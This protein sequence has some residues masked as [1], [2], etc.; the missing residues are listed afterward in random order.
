M[1][2]AVYH[3]YGA[4]DVLHLEDVPA[5]TPKADEVLIEIHATTVTAGDWRARSL[6]LPAGFG[7]LGR[8]V[9]GISKPRQPVLG[10]ELAGRVVAIGERVTDFAVGD[11]VF[12][13][14]GA[15]MGCHAEYRCISQ[16]G[17]IARIPD[18]LTYEQATALSFGGTTALEFLRKAKL[19]P[20]ERVLVVGASGGV[21]TA[22]LQLAK[23]FGAEV[24]GVCSTANLELVRSLGADHV[25]DYTKE[26]F[27]KSGQ[28]YDVIVDTAGTAPFSRSKHALRDGGRLL[29]VLGGLGDLFL[30]LWVSL[31]SRKKLIA[32]P[33][34]GTAEDLRLLARLA[35]A[36][37]VRP[38][39]DRRYP[40]AQIVEAHRYV[41]TGRKRGSVVM[42][43]LPE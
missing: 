18:A 2:A 30:A 13:F 8:L 25:I 9:F 40:F 32:G 33:T 39:I 24:T 10:T 17:P 14:P 5:P 3:R 29:R 41:D 6:E 37:E 16:A 38:V 22:A 26:D 19:Q 4:P 28:T 21:G 34:S 27:T 7:W 42:T 11:R 31:T 15:K 43:L 20:G 12:A 23:H 1:K 35:E 36:G